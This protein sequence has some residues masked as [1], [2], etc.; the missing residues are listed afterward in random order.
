MYILGFETTGARGSVALCN[1]ETREIREKSTEEPMGHLR[2][3]T[4]LAS[5]LLRERGVE[6][7]DLSGVAV[8]VGPGSYTGIRIGVSSA[9]A[10]AQALNITCFAVPSLEMFREKCDGKSGCAVIV[11]ARRGQVYGAVYEVMERRSLPR[12]HTCSMMSRRP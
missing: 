12:A 9:R 6:P 4:E 3:I 11:N 2:N 1:L 8:S 7:S 10:V 5:Q